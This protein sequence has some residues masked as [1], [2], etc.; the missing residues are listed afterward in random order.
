MLIPSQAWIRSNIRQQPGA[1]TTVRHKLAVGGEERAPTESTVGAP[2]RIGPRRGSPQQAWIASHI[3]VAFVQSLPARIWSDMATARRY[4]LR[5]G[6]CAWC[7]EIF[8]VCLDC[9]RGQLYCGETCGEISREA[10][11]RGYNRKYQK[12]P[13]AC[14]LHANRQKAYIQRKK[15]AGAAEEVTDHPIDRSGFSVKITPLTRESCRDMARCSFCGRAG[16]LNPLQRPINQGGQ[17]D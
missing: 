6:F 17:D 4:V 14:R 16:Y 10:K 13:K 7:R 5:V 15:A 3:S 2:L 9:E 12:T 1:R 11:C 8:F